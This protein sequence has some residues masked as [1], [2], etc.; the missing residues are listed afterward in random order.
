M[1]RPVHLE[2]IEKTASS[3]ENF[4]KEQEQRITA[5]VAAKLKG[6][7]K[8]NGQTKEDWQQGLLSS[9][10]GE[11]LGNVYNGL[12]ICRGPLWAGCLGYD[13][14]GIRPML[15]APP[16]DS[17]D[18]GPW[19]R[20][21]LDKDITEI[22][23][24]FQQRVN[25]RMTA[26]TVKA[27]LTA[28]ARDHSFYPLQDYLNSLRWDGKPRLDQWL[29][30]FF[31]ADNTSYV[32]SVASKTLLAAVARACQPGCKVDTVTILEGP[33]GYGKS[34]AWRILASD[35]W[36]SDSFID[37]RNKDA[38]LSLRR[39]WIVE[40]ADLS[41]VRKA[42][43]ETLKSWISSQSDYFRAPYADS[44]ED[45]PRQCIF[46]GSTNESQYLKD[47]T[48]NRRWWPVTVRHPCDASALHAERNQLWAE[49][50]AR[51][52]Q[53]ERWYLS[54]EQEQLA[55]NEQNER[56][57]TDEWE[58]PIADWLVN[59]YLTTVTHQDVM[60]EALKIEDRARWAGTEKRIGTIMRKLGW[61]RGSWRSPTKRWE[62]T[63]R[64]YRKPS[65]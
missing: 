50:V 4:L 48:G 61:E 51:Y 34:T 19:P 53:G 38:Y 58:Q 47:R 18:P 56:V 37:V 36:F 21:I 26:E 7:G 62:N 44:H 9:K 22:Q 65:A 2:S 8:G 64:S 10:T 41:A 16:P 63:R 43:V 49:A 15:L 35:S 6:N 52:H 24:W 20:P 54:D 27:V 13:G 17:Q 3:L 32:R 40:F 28:A 12:K 60:L 1:K 59:T 5:K 57:E 11:L 42:D 33:Q 31:G 46:V 39:K 23:A 45:H 55:R 29:C 30:H 14:F 25:P